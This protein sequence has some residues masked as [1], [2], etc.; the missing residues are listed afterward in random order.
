[1]IWIRRYQTTFV[2]KQFRFELQ[3]YSCGTHKVVVQFYAEIGNWFG[4]S[5]ICDDRTVKVF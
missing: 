5:D 4:I 3:K 1:M 2:K